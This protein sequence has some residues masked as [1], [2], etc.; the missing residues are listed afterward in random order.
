MGRPHAMY[1]NWDVAGRSDRRGSIDEKRPGCSTEGA[2]DGK[3][4]LW[5][6]FFTPGGA[7]IK[8]QCVIFS[9]D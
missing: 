1:L 8:D 4:V 2:S 6:R 5:R 7:V 3:N 9:G